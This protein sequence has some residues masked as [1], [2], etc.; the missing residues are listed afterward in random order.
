MGL[1]GPF[2]FKSKK[3]NKN[4]WLH[5]KI[6]GKTRLYYFSGDPKEALSSLPRGYEVVEDTKSGLPF[7]KKKKGGFF[8]GKSKVKKEEKKQEIK[9]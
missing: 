6:R 7:L 3:K 5:I 9:E 8:G 4:F 2:V 1:F